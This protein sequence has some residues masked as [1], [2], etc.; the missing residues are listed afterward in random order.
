MNPVIEQLLLFIGGFVANVLASLSGGGAGFVQLPLLIFM[1]LP[2]SLALGTHKVA[3]VALGL[4]SIAKNHQISNLNL[5][6]VLIFL[7]LGCPAVVAGSVMVVELKD[8]IAELSLGL[9]T[10]LSVIYSATKR[11]FG[12]INRENTLTRR[13]YVKA[14]FF[15]VLVGVLSGSFSSGAGLMA[16]MVMVTCYRM[17]IK[18]AIHHSMILVAFIWNLTGAVAMGTMASIHWEWVPMLVVGAFLGGFTGTFLIKYL[19][20][21]KIKILFQLIML[22][23]GIMLLYKAAGHYGM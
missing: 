20:A 5:R 6:A 17:D 14:A 9:I 15:T 13:D 22:L 19:D 12:L 21:S 23:S 1:G 4:G 8:W 16:I 11:Q 18:K 7:L 3:V 2:F 10:V